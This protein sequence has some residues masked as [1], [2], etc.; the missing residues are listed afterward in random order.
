MSAATVPLLRAAVWLVLSV[1]W[2]AAVCW[3]SVRVQLIPG[4]GKFLPLGL[5]SVVGGLALGLGMAALAWLAH[6]GN[7]CTRLVLATTGRMPVN[8]TLGIQIH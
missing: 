7:R 2:A 4:A 8:R 6:L 5:C 3:L 1:A